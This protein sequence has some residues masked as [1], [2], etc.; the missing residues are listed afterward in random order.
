MQ[1]QIILATLVV[2]TVFDIPVVQVALTQHDGL[3]MYRGI[4]PVYPAHSIGFLL[5]LGK[6]TEHVFG[7]LT[8]NT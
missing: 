6:V 2:V 8:F 7:I 3:Y 4:M 1:R 5:Y